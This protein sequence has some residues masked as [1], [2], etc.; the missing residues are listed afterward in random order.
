LLKQTLHKKE[1]VGRKPDPKRRGQLLLAT[2]SYLERNGLIGLS[3]RPLAAALGVSPRTLLYH[4]GSKEQLL[5]E[6]LDA[7]SAL[8]AAVEEFS[9]AEQPLFDRI[10]RLWERTTEP[11]SRPYLRLF[12]EVYAAALREPRKYSAFRSTVVDRWLD[13]VVPMLGDE[14]LARSE[15]RTTATELLALHH[16]CTLDLLATGDRDRVTAAY[17]AR[18]A[19]LE[20]RLRARRRPRA[21]GTR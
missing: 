17:L 2:A 19:E 12:F 1:A 8:R 15:A 6:A 4:F 11:R 3:L 14:G 10:R 7:S 18:L 20:S 21:R 9:A 16:G 5:A 13:L